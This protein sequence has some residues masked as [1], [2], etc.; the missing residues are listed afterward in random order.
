MNPKFLHFLCP[1]VAVTAWLDLKLSVPTPPVVLRGRWPSGGHKNGP[2]T[3]G[4]GPSLRDT[5]PEPPAGAVVLRS[6]GIVRNPA[7]ERQEKSVFSRLELKEPTAES[8]R[9]AAPTAAAGVPGYSNSRRVLGQFFPSI[10]FL[11]AR[12]V[13]GKLRRTDKQPLSQA[14]PRPG[15]PHLPHGWV[16]ASLQ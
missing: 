7:A 3:A 11:P 12:Q 6:K 16:P 1:E 9:G 5:A 14:R 4:R 8:T 15:S 2:C 13:M 10:L